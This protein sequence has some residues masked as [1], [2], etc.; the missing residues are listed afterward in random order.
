[1]TSRA[2][3]SAA[4]PASRCRPN[5]GDHFRSFDGKSRKFLVEGN[6]GPSWFTEY[7]VLAGLSSRSFGRFSYF[8]TRIASGRVERGLPMALRRCGY[9]TV[10][11]YPAAGAFMSAHNFQTRPAWSASSMRATMGA[12]GIEPDSF[13]YDMP[14]K[15]IAARASDRG[16]GVHVRLSRGQPFPVG[17]SLS[18]RSDC[19]TGAIPATRRTSTS[20]CAARP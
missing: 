20:I 11:L 3:T 13:Y 9:Q 14:L 18:S 8:V 6:G 4:R 12:K 19:R 15:E 17:R 10:S 2:S 16:A 7:N 5:Y 1:M